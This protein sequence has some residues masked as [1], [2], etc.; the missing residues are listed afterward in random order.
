MPTIRFQLDSSLP[1]ADVL[2]GITNFGADR[3]NVW[4][5]VDTSHFQ[6]H[7]SGPGWAEV[8]EGSAIAGG[9]WERE[10]YSWDA[11]R[12]TVAVETLDSNTWGAGSRWEYHLE[13]LAGGTRI[14]ATVV[15]NPKSWKGRLIGFGLAVAGPAMLRTQMQQAL[16]RIA[17]QPDA[18]G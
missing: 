9:V 3:A 6:V 1:P 10:R 13:P 2:A 4:P 8:T 12:G 17:A 11:A 18:D 15:R 7:R 14:V 5:N 16:A